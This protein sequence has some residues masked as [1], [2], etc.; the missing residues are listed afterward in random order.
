M[1]TA[2]AP[3]RVTDSHREASARSPPHKANK[4]ALEEQLKG[5]R[6]TRKGDPS[7][8]HP[9]LKWWLQEDNVLQGQQ[10]HPQICSSI[11][12]DASKKGGVLT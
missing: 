10:F 8:L 5:T 11:L 3:N 4:V 7:S 2:Y 1:L 12:T 9:R 6:I